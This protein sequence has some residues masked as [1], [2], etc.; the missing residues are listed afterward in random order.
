MSNKTHCRRGHERTPENTR[1]STRGARE[2]RICRN[3]SKRSWAQR[4]RLQNARPA[5]TKAAPTP[6]KESGARPDSLPKG[7]LKLAEKPPVRKTRG[8]DL[9]EVRA[10][11]P[12]EAELAARLLA[13]FDAADLMDALGL[14]DVTA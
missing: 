6:K 2:C 12:E 7:W 5:R 4:E 11:T 3:E 10:V 8:R 1:I 13:R 9:G 14:V